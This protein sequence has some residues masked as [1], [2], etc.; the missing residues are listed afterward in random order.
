M[1][2]SRVIRELCRNCT[3]R[4]PQPLR[5]V[6]RAEA[7]V[8][9]LLGMRSFFMIEMQR[10]PTNVY[11]QYPQALGQ[12]V[13]NLPRLEPQLDVDLKDELLRQNPLLQKVRDISANPSAYGLP[14]DWYDMPETGFRMQSQFSEDMLPNNFTQKELQIFEKKTGTDVHWFILEYLTKTGV[15]PLPF[16]IHRTSEGN[17]LTSPVYNNERSKI[18][19]AERHG[20]LKKTWEKAEQIFCD[21]STKEGTIIVINS[22]AGPSNLFFNKDGSETEFPDSQRYVL[23]K[24]G[25][26]I[27]G[28]TIRTSADHETEG[29]FIHA[30]SGKTIPLGSAPEAYVGEFITITPE[31]EDKPHTIAEVV[32]V[33]QSVHKNHTIAYTDQEDPTHQVSWDEIYKDLQRTEL[34]QFEETTKQI[35]E[36]WV[37]YA[38]MIGS[39]K[40]S[41]HVRHMLKAGLAVTLL[42]ISMYL[43]GKK[44]KEQGVLRRGSDAILIDEQTGKGPQNYGKT[45]EKV[46]ASGGCAGGG[47]KGLFQTSLQIIE[48]LAP[49]IIGASLENEDNTCSC[50]R[51]K[52]DNHY[53]CPDC[54]MTMDSEEGQSSFTPECPG[55]GFAYGC[56]EEDTNVIALPKPREVEEEAKAA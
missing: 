12:E 23:Q 56:S 44:A 38:N 14:H 21:P 30:L 6:F 13:F 33:M 18:L 27:V 41:Q 10:V 7:I 19:E 11:Q 20:V 28:Y 26:R 15:F 1:G 24:Q 43:E 47:K 4:S 16:D 52:E 49:R 45:L 39:Y 54:N 48:S 34:M 46:Q 29:K 35:Y 42:D 3:A 2:E 31:E 40:D 51:S 25:D 37:T 17:Y 50:G 8:M 5:A 32:K 55:C 36:K 9:Q 22:V 53:H